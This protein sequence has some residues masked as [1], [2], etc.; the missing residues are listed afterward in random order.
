MQALAMENINCREEKLPLGFK[1]FT[2]RSSYGNYIIVINSNLNEALKGKLL[3]K[4]KGR[5][6][7]E[8]NQICSIIDC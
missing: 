1:G 7:N 6:A 3:A 8:I 5:I 4:E 2:Y